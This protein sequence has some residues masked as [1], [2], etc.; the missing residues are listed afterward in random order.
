MFSCKMC[1]VFV[2]H[3]LAIDT[4]FLVRAMELKVSRL[5]I[6]SEVLV[7]IGLVVGDLDKDRKLK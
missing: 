7:H 6:H 2:Q 3:G 1:R 5:L 4:F